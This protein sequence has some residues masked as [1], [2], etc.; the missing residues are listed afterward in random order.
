[1]GLGGVRWLL[2]GAG[3]G[4]G[5]GAWEAGQWRAAW[6]LSLREVLSCLD[7]QGELRW[8]EELFFHAARRRAGDALKG[9]TDRNLLPS[10][11]SAV[12]G[13]QQEAL[14]RALDSGKGVGGVKE[15]GACS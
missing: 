12:L 14:L 2:G 7:Q 5:A 9:R 10:I 13:G 4:G 6:R 3:A 1:M 15:L 11:R 8:R